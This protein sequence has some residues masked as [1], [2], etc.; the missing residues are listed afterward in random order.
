VPVPQI[1]GD[2]PAL[3][4]VLMERVEGRSDFPAVDHEHEREPTARHLMEIAAALHRID[5]GTI[6]APHLGVPA[7][8]TVH[9]AQR[10]ADLEVTAAASDAARDPLLAGAL[11]WLRAAAPAS[12]RTALVHSDLGPGNF[13]AREGRVTAVL[14]WEVAHFGDPMEDLAA[15]SIRDMATPV[16]DLPTRFHEYEAAAG[17]P[18]DLERVRY[19]RVLILA[20]N[21]MLLDLGLDRLDASMDGAQLTM[22]R[23][24][25]HRALGLVL[26]D[27]VGTTRPALRDALS[28]DAAEAGRVGRLAAATAQQLRDV[29]VPAVGDPLAVARATGAAAVVEHLA[30]FATLGPAIAA[31]DARD[32]GI[33]EARGGGPVDGACAA[34]LARHGLR[35]AAP[36]RPLLGPLADRL[37]QPLVRP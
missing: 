8:P 19:Y 20:R 11:D 25:L 30:L 4:V 32:A 23:A 14:D 18:V 9:A 13:L 34:A 28:A 29:V 15:L 26:C 21:T 36:V 37:P 6:D 35:A 10:I 22:Y 3:G 33:W 5:P 1:V 16:G 17:V 2:E 7:D 12:D 24:L 27:A 31:A